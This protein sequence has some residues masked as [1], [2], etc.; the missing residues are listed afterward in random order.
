MAADV[1]T[2]NGKSAATVNGGIHVIDAVL[3]SGFFS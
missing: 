1:M 3:L 2:M